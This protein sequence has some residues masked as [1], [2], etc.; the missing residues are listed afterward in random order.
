[1]VSLIAHVATQPSGGLLAK[2]PGVACLPGRECW[3]P[4][5]IYAAKC[6]SSS[7][8][9]RTAPRSNTPAKTKQAGSHGGRSVPAGSCA[10]ATGVPAV[11]DALEKRAGG[12]CSSI[13]QVT[14]TP[15]FLTTCTACCLPGLR[16]RNAGVPAQ[17]CHHNQL[18]APPHSP[19]QTMTSTSVSDFSRPLG[20]CSWT[21]PVVRAPCTC[22][23]CLV[24]LGRR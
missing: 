2:P 11:A 23:S 9:G 24:C 8:A 6:I 16:A 5:T 1:M 21:G 10:A 13:G 7:A 15:A 19:P 12:C 18:T 3:P 14:G 17:E 4:D 20:C 22:R